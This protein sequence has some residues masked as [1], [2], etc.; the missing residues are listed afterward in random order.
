MNC[1]VFKI[2]KT[3]KSTKNRSFSA[4]SLVK[5]SIV[6]EFTGVV[7]CEISGTK[8]HSLLFRH[9]SSTR[10]RAIRSSD[11]QS[12]ER[13]KSG[14]GGAAR[15]DGAAEQVCGGEKRQAAEGRDRG[16]DQDQPGRRIAGYAAGLGVFRIE[17][18]AE[19]EGCRSRPERVPARQKL[20]ASALEV[21]WRKA[22]AGAESLQEARGC[23]SDNGQGC[24]PDLQRSLVSSWPEKLALR[25]NVEIF[26]GLSFVIC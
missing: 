24:L 9:K 26:R 13:P 4:S 21:V 20:E 19:G 25:A 6:S 7:D 22:G 3:F 12:I 5:E 10:A 17:P 11:E 18:G 14:I 23:Y 15:L 1:L 8:R 2:Y 16:R